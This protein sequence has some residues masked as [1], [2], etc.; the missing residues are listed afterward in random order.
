[1]YLNNPF[2]YN[3]SYKIHTCI[4]LIL[5]LLLGFI[6]VVLQP[7]NINNLEHDYS[8]VLLMGFGF[9][10]FVNYLL[11]HF[12]ENIYYKK[13]GNWTLWN[14]IAFILLSSFSAA[15]LGYIYLDTVFEKQSLSFLRL[16]LFLYYI[17]L[18]IIPLVVFPKSVLRFLLTKKS[19]GDNKREI[20]EDGSSVLEKITLKGQNAKDKLTVSKKDLLY[21][22]SVDN[23]V[24][25]YYTNEQTKSIMLRAKMS[26]ILIQA[27]FLIQPH[28]SYLINPTHAFRIKGNSQK[29]VLISQNFEAVIPIAR[30]SYK[31]VKNLFN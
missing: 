10:K 27:P 3:S 7:F 31:T 30:T 2:P 22:K 11:S 9:V 29:A 14:E 28:R 26:E 21:V 23:Y 1:M 12:I 19:I 15:I 25:V 24:M 4:G 17:V 20:A 18:P 8:E 13:K 6:L 16:V 5:G